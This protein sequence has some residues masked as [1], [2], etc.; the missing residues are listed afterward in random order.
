[1]ILCPP[2]M[3]NVGS[4]NQETARV[5]LKSQGSSAST[6]PQSTQSNVRP[7][8]KD[9]TR[10]PRVMRQG[11][12]EMKVLSKETDWLSKAIVTHYMVSIVQA[13]IYSVQW[14]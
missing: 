11:W 7:S 9:S 3:R 8:S 5:S 4:G 1:M 10:S 2:Y 12:M 14:V 6:R 13:S